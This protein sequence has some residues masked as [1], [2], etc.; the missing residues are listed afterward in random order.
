MTSLADLLPALAL[1]SPQQLDAV[2]R[3]LKGETYNINAGGFIHA[4]EPLLTLRE[5]APRVGVSAPTLW[6]WNVPGHQL[7]GRPRYRLSEV[8]AYLESEEFKR[9]AAALR[10]E[11]KRSKKSANG[12]M[13]PEGGAK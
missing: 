5:L 1:A 7:G 9:R 6:R 10:A 13:G 2:N 8:L 11:R 3:V 4:I 12:K